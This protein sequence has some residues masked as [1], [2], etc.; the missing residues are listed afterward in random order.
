MPGSWSKSLQSP[1]DPPDKKTDQWAQVHRN[2]ARQD[3]NGPGGIFTE[4]LVNLISQ[5][6]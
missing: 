2:N 4:D 6:E 1:Y 5:G 3:K